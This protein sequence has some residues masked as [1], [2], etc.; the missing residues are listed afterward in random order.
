MTQGARFGAFK[1][2]LTVAVVDSAG[3]AHR[4]TSEIL[5][6]GDGAQRIR[7]PSPTRP[8]RVVL[9]PDVALLARLT[10]VEQ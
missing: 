2:P 10:L 9:D 3:A 8:A 4:A 1:F 6:V 7:I 5:A